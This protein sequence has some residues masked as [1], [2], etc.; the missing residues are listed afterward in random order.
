MTDHK[1]IKA[2]GA[3]IQE[4][5]AILG[6][7][8][9]STRIKASLIANDSTPLAAGSYEWENQLVNGIWT[10]DLDEVW[11]GTAGCY[12]SLVKNV[13][14]QYGVELT[15]LAAL[16]F[17]G[18]MHGY[19][20]LDRTGKLLT[21]FRT[22]RNNITEEACDKLTPLFNFA[23]P[24]RW[25]IAHLYQ[26]ILENQDHVGKI[27]YLTTLAGYVHYRLTG[28]RVMGIGEASGMFP[29]DPNT[30][31][32]DQRMVDQFDALVAPKGYP[33]KLKQILPQVL[34]A[35]DRAGE[36]TPEGAKLLDPSGKLEEVESSLVLGGDA[37]TGMVATNSVR[38]RTGNVSA[39]TSVFAMIVLEKT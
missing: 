13:R 29:I 27:E 38:S 20:V 28:K 17:S 35:G 34:V 24:Q 6:I 9:G 8:F 15:S 7:E 1:S 22:W 10:Y 23:I 37:G 19:I 12:A 25:S 36:L 18:M 26:S 33:W 30:G 4:G 3:L 31:D 5:K 21:P 16:G 11:K 32:Y 14:E 2:P 39:G